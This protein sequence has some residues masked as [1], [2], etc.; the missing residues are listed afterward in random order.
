MNFHWSKSNKP[1]G[2]YGAR[3]FQWWTRAIRTALV[4][5][6][7]DSVLTLL[8]RFSDWSDEVFKIRLEGSSLGQKG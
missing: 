5:E 2:P 1:E 6:I 3:Y 7:Q 4:H 8:A